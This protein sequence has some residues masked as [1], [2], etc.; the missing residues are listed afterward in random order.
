MVLVTLVGGNP[1]IE[2]PAR[3]RAAMRYL[4]NSAVFG[5]LPHPPEAEPGNESTHRP[6]LEAEHAQCA[7]LSRNDTGRMAAAALARLRRALGTNVRSSN[8]QVDPQSPTFY[9]RLGSQMS[10]RRGARYKIL[11]R[12]WG[13]QRIYLFANHGDEAD[14]KARELAAIP[15]QSP[16]AVIDTDGGRSVTFYF[17]DGYV[18]SVVRKP[19]R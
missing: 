7:R 1:L 4:V 6:F 9:A 8:E 18:C 5:L 2:Q 11:G 10:T 3:R 17:A 12:G 19:P 15:G 14:A 16:V 13:A